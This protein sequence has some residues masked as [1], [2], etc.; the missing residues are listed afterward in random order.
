MSE[1]ATIEGEV[2]QLKRLQG[3]FCNAIISDH[4]SWVTLNRDSEGR[5][6]SLG[7]KVRVTGVLLNGQF[8]TESWER[9]TDDPHIS[10]RP[11]RVEFA[12]EKYNLET[13]INGT[14]AEVVEYYAQGP[15]AR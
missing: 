5:W 3:S 2:I 11:I 4:T 9:V 7:E 6:P 15:I 13:T 10:M 14:R 12:D 8:L 1:S